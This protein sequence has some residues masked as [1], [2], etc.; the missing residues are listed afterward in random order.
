MSEYLTT[1]LVALGCA[2]VM[3]AVFVGVE[4]LECSHGRTGLQADLRIVWEAAI[5]PLVL[6]PWREWFSMWLPN[7][8]HVLGKWVIAP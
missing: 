1:V 8:K 2:Y 7:G 4:A 6:L 5:W 3:I